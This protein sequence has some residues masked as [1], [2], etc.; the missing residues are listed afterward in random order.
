MSTSEKSDNICWKCSKK[1]TEK[2]S[3]YDLYRIGSENTITTCLN[4]A[5][6]MI[7][8]ENGTYDHILYSIPQLIKI[9]DLPIF[10]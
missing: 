1:F 9:L 7:K 5:V 2:D 4:C 10:N 8:D 6:S 3:L